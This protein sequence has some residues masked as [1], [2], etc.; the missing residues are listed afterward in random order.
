MRFRVRPV[1][2]LRGEAAVPG[3]KSISHRAVL[4]GAIAE[5]VTEVQG[6][7]EAEDC[8]RTVAAVQ[9]LGVDVTRK[10]PGHYRIAGGGLRGL[11]EPGDVIDCG[12]S[13]T[14]AR[15]LSSQPGPWDC[16]RRTETRRWCVGGNLPTTCRIPG[17]GKCCQSLMAGNGARP[18]ESTSTRRTALSG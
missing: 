11:H 6:Y 14:T 13:G 10:G 1:R 8:L 2:R 12:N 17:S 4:L 16:P 3:D 18:L 9:A 5:G 15:L 7:L